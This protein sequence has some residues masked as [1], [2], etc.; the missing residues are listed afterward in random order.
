MGGPESQLRNDF[1]SRQ[2]ELFKCCIARLAV[3]ELDVSRVNSQVLLRVGMV[4]EME[5]DGI[6]GVGSGQLPGLEMK[7]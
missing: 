2:Y 5:D 3:K 7:S 6:E 1:I 4:W